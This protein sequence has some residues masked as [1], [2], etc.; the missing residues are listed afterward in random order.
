MTEPR[1][2]EGWKVRVVLHGALLH[3]VSSTEPRVIE[4]GGEL[5]G[6]DWSPTDEGDVPGYVDWSAVRAITWRRAAERR[7]ARAADEP[8]GEP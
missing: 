8:E 5:V 7:R 2:V 1:R 3:V 6:V 4:H